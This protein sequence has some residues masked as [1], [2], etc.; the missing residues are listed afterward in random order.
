[1]MEIIVC[2]WISNLEVPYSPSYLDVVG[3]YCY[4]RKDIPSEVE[5]NQNHSVVV[6][7]VAAAVAVVHILLAK[8]ER[9]YYPYCYE[10]LRWEDCFGGNQSVELLPV[11]VVAL[12]GKR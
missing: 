7:V 9:S 3:L 5:Y 12:V 8:K 6:V 2:R 11:A 4:Q 10:R 1:M